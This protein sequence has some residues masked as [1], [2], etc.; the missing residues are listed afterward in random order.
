MSDQSARAFLVEAG[1][2][3]ALRAKVDDAIA[4]CDGAELSSAVAA[5]GASEGFSFSAAEIDAVREE[6]LEETMLGDVRGGSQQPMSGF[7]PTTSAPGQN[8]MPV[9]MGWWQSYIG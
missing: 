8:S 4:A 3:T 1:I 5:V 9:V 7:D 2:N 6:L